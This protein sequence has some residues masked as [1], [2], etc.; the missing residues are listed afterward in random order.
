VAEKRKKSVGKAVGAIMLTVTLALA[1]IVVLPGLGNFSQF[2]LGSKD[3]PINIFQLPTTAPKDVP[4]EQLVQYALQLINSNRAKFSLPPV[5]LSNNEAAQVHAEDVYTTKQISHWMT[6]GEKPYMTYTRYG[7]TGNVHQNV[8]IAGFT[9]D[10]YQKCNAILSTCQVIDPLSALKQLEYEMVYDDVSCCDNGH[11]ENILDPHH[12]Q[13]SIGIAYDKYYLAFVENFEDNYGLQTSVSD[14]TVYLTGHLSSGNLKQ[15]EVHYDPLPTPAAYEQNKQLLSYSAG[16]LIAAVAPPLPFGYSY[17][18]PA[19][20]RVIAA[21]E[22]DVSADNSVNVAFRLGPIIN[23]QG[24]TPATQAG[25]YT[26]YA[27]V[28]DNQGRLFEVT[29]YSIFVGGTSSSSTTSTTTNS[30]ATTS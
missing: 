15:I 29:S 1:A 14:G 11:R 4:R 23:L 3:T 17:R 12:T 30:P 20:Y 9:A 6:N 21:N 19:D 7:G 16:K 26:T 25:V 27:V 10:Q 13:V 5:Q 22:W 24:S 18:Q 8:A 2:F 28:E